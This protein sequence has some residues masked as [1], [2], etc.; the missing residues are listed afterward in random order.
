MVVD[1]ISG[2]TTR[3]RS[4]NEWIDNSI[5][6]YTSGFTR[7]LWAEDLEDPRAYGC[8]VLFTDLIHINRSSSLPVLDRAPR[9]VDDYHANGAVKFLD[10]WRVKIL[11]HTLGREVVLGFAE[12]EK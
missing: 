12:S 7:T 1:V 4:I 11:C 2:L 9:H 8:Y 3:P 10:H 6:Q 5:S